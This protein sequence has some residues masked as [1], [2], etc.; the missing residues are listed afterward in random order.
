MKLLSL[1]DVL[2]FVIC[3]VG[4]CFV[5]LNYSEVPLFVFCGFWIVLIVSHIR[6]LDYNTFF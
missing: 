5:L 3:L 4:G 1:F 2:L 6:I